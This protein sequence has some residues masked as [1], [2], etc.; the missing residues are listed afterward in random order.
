VHWQISR[1]PPLGG[2]VFFHGKYI[3]K[4]REY[5][6]AYPVFVKSP[7]TYFA[8]TKHTLNDTKQALH[9]RPNTH[10][11]LFQLGDAARRIQSCTRLLGPQRDLPVNV[12]ILMLR[13]FLYT[14]VAR[15]RPSHF[16]TTQQSFG[17]P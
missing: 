6:Q 17:L 11:L 9:F 4:T 2:H 16:S 10:F 5:I 14:G 3:R 1:R 7:V 12:T 13:A 8:V 15:I